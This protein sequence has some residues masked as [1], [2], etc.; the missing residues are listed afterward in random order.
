MLQHRQH[1]QELVQERT[2]ELEA[3]RRA[4]D[5][6]NVAK[7]A[8]LANI[9]HEI[10][11]PM[12]GILG[13]ANLL[14]RDGVTP[15]QAERLDKIDIA[16]QHLLGLIN[17]VLDFSKIEAGKVQLDESPVVVSDLLGNVVTMLSDRVKAKG[18][19]L[20]VQ[21][22]SLPE[23]LLGDAARL[24]QA[25]LNYAS[26][27]IKFT[28]AGS[29]TLRIHA[30]EENAD[31]VLLRFEVQ[32]TGVGIAPDAIK[33][34]F[35]AFEQA[36]NS[37]TRKYGGTGLGLAITRRLAEL[38]GGT[39]GVHSTLGVG[40]TFWFSARLKKG[41][42]ALKASAGP[43]LEAE[44]QLRQRF[45]GMVVLLVDDEPLN[46]EVARLQL[47]NA[48]VLVDTAQDGEQALAMAGKTRYASILMDMQMPH[49]NGLDATRRIRALE[50]YRQTPIIAMTANAFAE[51]KARC[52]Q[53]GMSD[54]LAKPFDADTL[55]ATLLRGLDASQ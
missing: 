8:F 27:A 16:A 55:Y 40:S 18:L 15:A 33:R 51:D 53:V 22:E 45:A 42:A 9:S 10:R 20:L 48:G 24:H 7:S 36:D 37:T 4:A 30:Q 35:S 44:A 23:N 47:E 13:M 3:A 19:R 11:T 46:L 25:L 5:D 31:S 39:V 49:L 41:V 32:D 1:L 34:L 43:A 50:G 6:A 17:N 38:M 12:N 2:A 28:E 26:N 54:F 29:V 14:R 52:L 21:A